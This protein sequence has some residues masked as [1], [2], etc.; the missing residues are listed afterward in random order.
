MSVPLYQVLPKAP[1]V[2]DEKIY[3]TSDVALLEVGFV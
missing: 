3:E 2:G 1:L